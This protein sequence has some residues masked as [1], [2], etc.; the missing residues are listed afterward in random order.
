MQIQWAYADGKAI[1]SKNITFN[2]QLLSDGKRVNTESKWTFIAGKD[3]DNKTIV[4]RSENS[5]LKEPLTAS[6]RLDVKYA[7]E[8]KLLVVEPIGQIRV[9]DNV[10]FLCEANANPMHQLLYKWF[11]NDEIIIGENS[12]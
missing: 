9:G 3:Y 10:V 11:K 2:S 6:I 7:P 12:N 1:I 8:V 5:A 4:C